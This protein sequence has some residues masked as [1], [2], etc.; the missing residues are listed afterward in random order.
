MI[1]TFETSLKNISHVKNIHLQNLKISE[2]EFKPRFLVTEH[3][4]GS[5]LLEMGVFTAEY[6]KQSS[7]Y[8]NFVTR[9]QF[10][11]MLS[12]KG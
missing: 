11:Y 12:C 1:V 4:I 7:V 3:C 5:F 10:C 2:T 9:Q 6:F 8:V